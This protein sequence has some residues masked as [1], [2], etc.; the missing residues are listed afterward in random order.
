MR[1]EEIQRTWKLKGGS[2][3]RVCLKD[4]SHFLNIL[5]VMDIS[6]DISLYFPPKK[7]PKNALKLFVSLDGKKNLQ[8]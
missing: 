7:S 2:V 6:L 4:L 1:R 3:C 5:A 8:M